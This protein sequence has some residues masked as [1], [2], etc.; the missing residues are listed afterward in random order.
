MSWLAV[1]EMGSG[2][3]E[4]YL[5]CYCHVFSES[6]CFFFFS[7]AWIILSILKDR[8]QLSNWRLDH[9][10]VSLTIP[11]PQQSHSTRSLFY[12]TQLQTEADE[13]THT[14]DCFELCVSHP[15]PRLQHALAALLLEN[16]NLWGLLG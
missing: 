15:F 4:V 12:M 16:A 11:A 9:L 8:E 10:L 13:E 14:K 3:S 2:P 6:H 1:Q 5:H 7:L